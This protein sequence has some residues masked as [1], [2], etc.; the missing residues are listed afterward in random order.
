MAMKGPWWLSGYEEH[1]R[2]MKCIVRDLET[3]GLDPGR[4]KVGVCSAFVPIL[5]VAKLSNEMV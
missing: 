5:L 4:F 2:D 1:L 3:V